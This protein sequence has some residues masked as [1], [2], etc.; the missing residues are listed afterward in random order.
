MII[1]RYDDYLLEQLLNESMVNEKINI[2]KIKSLVKQIGNKKEF[3]KKLLKKFNESKNLNTKKY[4]TYL[5]AAIL[6]SNSVL[7]N[8]KLKNDDYYQEINKAS[9]FFMDVAN[10]KG[11]ISINDIE[12][13]E[14]TVPE[15]D[16]ITGAN[17][18]TPL[19]IMSA[20]QLGFI[21]AV[22][23]VKPGRLDS[24]KIDRYDMYDDDILKACEELR[25][26]GETPNP[27]F[28]K[29]IMMIETGMNPTKNSLGFEG[30]P[31]T[32]IEYI[33]GRT[34]KDGKYHPGIN[35]KY[36]TNFTIE[37]MYDAGKSAKFIHYYLKSLEKSKHINTPEDMLIAYNWGMGNLYNYKMGR[38]E[39]PKQSSDYV[40]MYDAMKPFYAGT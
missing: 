19:E 25:M 37:D 7:N 5:L 10:K 11:E 40:D 27:N 6:I 36:G 16:A 32:K 15:L 39:L 23:D 14:V 34:D 2:D 20:S 30:F 4:L 38:K 21:D 9:V 12:G 35:Q 17:P 18:W 31:Q 22:N 28:I 1:T 29:T 26:K 24:T 33:N 8:K 13:F 3:I